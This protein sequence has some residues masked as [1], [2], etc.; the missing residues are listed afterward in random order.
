MADVSS[1]GWMFEGGV[2][3]HFSRA[4]TVYGFWEHG[5][6]DQGELNSAGGGRGHTNAVGIGVNA[7]TSPAGPMGFYFDMGA[8]YRWMNFADASTDPNV[9]PRT[10]TTVTGFDYLRAAVGVSINVSPRFRLDPHVYAS[11]GYFTEFRGASCHG[12][13]SYEGRSFESG[14]HTFSGVAVAGRWDLR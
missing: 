1:W 4:W 12:A 11:S 7:N 8:S 9:A 6:L 13:C 5:E 2:G 14:F 3:Y 10:R